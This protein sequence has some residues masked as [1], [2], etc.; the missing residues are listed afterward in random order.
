M[1]N[2]EAVP[3]DHTHKRRAKTPSFSSILLDAIYRSIDADGDGGGV[4]DASY[5]HHDYPITTAT[6]ATS[7]NKYMTSNYNY[8]CNS[9]LAGSKQRRSRM[10][11]DNTFETLD[12]RH[13]IM[14]ESWMERQE[15]QPQPYDHGTNNANDQNIRIVR[16]KSV[17]SKSTVWDTSTTRHFSKSRTNLASR[18]ADS[19]FAPPMKRELS[20]R[21]FTKTKSRAMKIY[22]DLKKPKSPQNQPI[23]PGARIAAFI[24]SIFRNSGDRKPNP[25]SPASL[26]SSTPITSTCSSSS[27]FS[28][29]CLSK[30]TSSARAKSSSSTRSVRFYPVSVIADEDSRPCGHRSLHRED[31]TP[32]SKFENNRNQSKCRREEEIDTLM[33]MIKRNCRDRA[34]S[35]SFDNGGDDSNEEM[36]DGESCA[37]SDL[38]ELENLSS[39]GVSRYAEELPVY[40]TTSLHKI[41][42]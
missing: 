38:F 24:N 22:G 1:S 15:Q 11:S 6:A 13:A 30:T 39:I 4:A 35:S 23:S 36:N 16:Q 19:C 18:S 8:D 3:F 9:Y 42:G 25:P 32:K 31:E 34:A 10:R 12:L 27:S 20:S 5:H 37:S 41:K 40:G 7:I 2:F 29:S 33:K 21:I 26:S 28:R 17:P 14:I